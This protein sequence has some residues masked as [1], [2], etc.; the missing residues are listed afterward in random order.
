M[1]ADAGISLAD[2]RISAIPTMKRNGGSTRRN[3]ICGLN[4][5]SVRDMIFENVGQ[6]PHFAAIRAFR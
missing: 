4:F 3:I 1:S 2:F 6:K 5:S